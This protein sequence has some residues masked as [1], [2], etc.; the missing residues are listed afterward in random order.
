MPKIASVRETPFLPVL[1]FLFG[2][3]IFKIIDPTETWPESTDIFLPKPNDELK[4]T[5]FLT[6][7][8]KPIVFSLALVLAYLSSSILIGYRL[9]SRFLASVD[10]SSVVKLCVAFLPG[11][12][13][14]VGLVRIVTIMFSHSS[15]MYLGFCLPIVTAIACSYSLLNS[16]KAH[17]SSA[18]SNRSIPVL[19]IVVVF[20][21]M[22]ITR[23]QLGTHFL[24]GDGTYAFLSYYHE[25]L[26][27]IATRANERLPLVDQHYD[28]FV[29][30]YPL[31]LLGSVKLNSAFFFWMLNVVGATACF[32]AYYFLFRKLRL[33]VI[34]SVIATAFIFWGSYTFAPDNYLLM[35]DS[36][37]PQDG[38]TG[39]NANTGES[40]WLNTVLFL[41]F[42]IGLTAVS[43]Q[44][45][46]FWCLTSVAWIIYRFGNGASFLG[47]K[48]VLYAVS[49]M[50]LMPFLTYGVLD[51]LSITNAGVPVFVSA[52]VG[53]GVLGYWFIYNSSRLGQ[54]I[55]RMNH[56]AFLLVGVVILTLIFAVSFG[57]VG[58]ASLRS[59]F[60]DYVPDG[61]FS[62]MLSRDLVSQE[63]PFHIF[64]FSACEITTHC[65]NIVHFIGYYGM[66]FAMTLSSFLLLRTKDSKSDGTEST[67]Y[68]FFVLLFLTLLVAALFFTDFVTGR[69]WNWL[70]TRFIEVPTIAII[71]L[72]FAT[73]NSYYKR[74]ERWAVFAVALF[75]T[76][77]PYAANNRVGQFIENL[78]YFPKLFI[79]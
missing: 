69:Y 35:F 30:N 70:S 47:S 12:L 19:G 29:F 25:L 5:P 13:V 34:N 18:K 58:T 44:N 32:Y 23:V 67:F 71:I 15:A 36:G 6:N 49:F 10:V 50:C 72:F 77:L 54:I 1:V 26:S 7:G 65:K 78:S 59:F 24:V 37:N 74:Q 33:N 76:V 73:V 2:V 75:W 79:N 48:K 63:K 56:T 16:K 40:D 61:Y 28:E 51:K 68:S 39:K 42:C 53:V 41:L 31:I 14:V 21:I 3:I 17:K 55:R 64:A 57:N 60:A 52:C 8:L 66:L 27:S 22:L 11:Y 62:K 20:F 45:V 43:I 46:L 4:F 9:I 38:S